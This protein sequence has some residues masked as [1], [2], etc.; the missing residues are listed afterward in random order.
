MSNEYLGAIHCRTQSPKAEL[1]MGE[2]IARELSSLLAAG[3]M[4]QNRNLN[5]SEIDKLADAKYTAHMLRT[6]FEV[7]PWSPKSRNKGYTDRERE[8][9]QSC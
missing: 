5:L 9:K 3:L 4:Y 8:I 2:T 1:L 7:R 6:E